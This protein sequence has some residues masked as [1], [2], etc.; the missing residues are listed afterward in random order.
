MLFEDTLDYDLEECGSDIYSFTIDIPSIC[1]ADDT[2]ELST[3]LVYDEYLEEQEEHI[4]FSSH[5]KI[6]NSS[7][8]FDECDE[9]VSKYVEQQETL[10]Q[11]ESNQ[12]HHERDQPMYDSYQE[13][14]WTT[15]EGHKEGLLKQLISP[16]YGLHSRK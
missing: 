13:D 8:L 2:P 14:L 11:Q 1:L 15:C 4:Y 10:V 6:Y 5:M 7:P 16:P 12:Q 9:S 3:E